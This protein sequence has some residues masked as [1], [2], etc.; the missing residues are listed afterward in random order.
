VTRNWELTRRSRVL[1]EKLIV[2]QMVKRF[3]SFYGTQRLTAM[4][5][6]IRQWT[7]H[8]PDKS[9]PYPHTYFFKIFLSGFTT[10]IEN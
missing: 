1:L 9:N 10:K 6:R 5:A 7:Y 2:A 4:F 8:V 3:S